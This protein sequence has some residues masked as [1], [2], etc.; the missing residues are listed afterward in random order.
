[1]I[2]K[3][4][5]ILAEGNEQIDTSIENSVESHYM[6]IAAEASRVAGGALV[7]VAPYRK[8]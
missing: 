5:E 6:A 3:L 8:D 1:M 7:E 4:Y 2:D